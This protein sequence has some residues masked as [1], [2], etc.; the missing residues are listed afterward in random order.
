MTIRSGT[1]RSRGTS[2]PASRVWPTDEW[3]ASV[4]LDS[5]L[6]GRVLGPEHAVAEQRLER[7]RDLG[8]QIVAPLGRVGGGLEVE[9]GLGLQLPGG[10]ERLGANPRSG[11]VLAMVTVRSS[12]RSASS[13]IGAGSLTIDGGTWSTAAW[14]SLLVLVWLRIRE[15]LDVD[16]ELPIG[17]LGR[18]G[19]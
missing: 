6:R 3:I 19:S 15:F 17:P 9:E 16:P 5:S 4:E 8:V 1:T 11:R 7:R 2:R 14:R 18:A 10:A 12:S 13:R